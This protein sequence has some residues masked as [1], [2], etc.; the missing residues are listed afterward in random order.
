MDE[1][2]NSISIKI[3]DDNLNTENRV[4]ANSDIDISNNSQNNI[5]NN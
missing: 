5:N 4:I 3:D 1:Q 2:T